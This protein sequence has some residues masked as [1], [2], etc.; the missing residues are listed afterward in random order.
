MPNNDDDNSRIGSCDRSRKNLNGEDV[1]QT[2]CSRIFKSHSNTVLRYLRYEK[3]AWNI[4]AT[5]YHLAPLV[6]PSSKYSCVYRF[7]QV[8]PLCIRE[9]SCTHITQES[10]TKNPVLPPQQTACI[11]LNRPHSGRKQQQ[12]CPLT[13]E[14]ALAR[15]LKTLSSGDWL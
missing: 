6:M 3:R 9:F 8:C 4:P 13:C 7:S 2:C 15:C 12:R 10:S 5:L 11:Q 1:L 14:Y